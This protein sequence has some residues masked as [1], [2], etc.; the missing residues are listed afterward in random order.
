MAA[1][2]SYIVSA[3]DRITTVLVYEIRTASAAGVNETIFQGEVYPPSTE[4]KSIELLDLEEK[5]RRLTVH[6]L[7]DIGI[8]TSA[9]R[10]QTVEA[11]PEFVFLIRAAGITIKSMPVIYKGVVGWWRARQDRFIAAYSKTAVVLIDLNQGAGNLLTV[12]AGLPLLEQ[13][14][15][16]VFPGL[17][18]HISL[19]WKLS[20]RV[21]A[22]VSVIEAPE[23]REITFVRGSVRRGAIVKLLK[24]L[25]P[26]R[27]GNLDQDLVVLTG[28]RWKSLWLNRTWV[29]SRDHPWPQKRNHLSPHNLQK[30]LNEAG[31]R[32]AVAITDRNC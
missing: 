26:A 6:H 19:S 29:L 4:Q 16:G 17:N 9:R 21:L 23:G 22:N 13:K 15:R 25:D 1:L 32:E 11:S 27:G 30:R 10:P 7:N 14:I 18:L 12:V 3:E 28:R 24:K 5:V 8:P 20:A 2:G 31:A